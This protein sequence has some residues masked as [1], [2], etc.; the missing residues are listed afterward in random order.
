[1]LDDKNFSVLMSVY[2]N[3]DPKHFIDSLESILNQTIKPSE[4][5]LVRDGQVPKELQEIIDRYV[6]TYDFFNYIPLEE[7]SGLGNAL[8]IGLL[9]TK[10][11]LVARMDTDDIATENR[12]E[13]QLD[14]FNQNPDTSICGG[15]ILEFIDNPENIVAKRELP[16]THND[17]CR[18]LKGRCPFNHMTVMFKKADVLKAG[19]YQPFL[20]MEDY[21]LWCR[22]YLNGAVFANLNESLVLARVG[23]DMY[24]R[25]GGFNY[26][27]SGYRLEKFKLQ[28][29]IV[30]MF[31]FLKRVSMRFVI[32]VLMPNALRGWVLKT[33]CRKKS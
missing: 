30:G 8:N 20:F 14:Y 22:M 5:V 29:K 15:Q 9:H 1:M 27:K 7:N 12:F 24:R 19:N 28:N 23:E 31:E 25:R 3:E 4:I 18:F 32:Q 33:F 2:K 17:I 11:D 10:Y 26:F 6:N 13:L 16:L 21:Y